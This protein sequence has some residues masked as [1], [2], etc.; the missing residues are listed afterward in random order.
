L[1]QK[2][3]ENEILCGKQTNE[4]LKVKFIIFGTTY[5]CLPVY[6]FGDIFVINN[7]TKLVYKAEKWFFSSQFPQL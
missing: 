7:L 4:A 2:E 6:N 5:L 1:K 3:N